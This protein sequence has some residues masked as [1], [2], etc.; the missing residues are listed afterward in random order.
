MLNVLPR[1]LAVCNWINWIAAA[2]LVVML[3][4]SVPYETVILA[5]LAE[6]SNAADAATVLSTVRL[7]IAAS[8]PVAVALHLIFTR[9]RTIVLAARD[10]DPFIADNAA[11]LR[12]IGWA[13][14]ATQ[15]LDLVFG[16]V[17]W[18]IDSRMNGGTMGWSP[19]LTAWLAVLLIFVLARVFETGAAMRDDLEGTV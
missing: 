11:R 8:I 6:H 17:S 3:I 2:L 18:Q 16:Y 19:S 7:A 5:K 10:G 1:L 13:L 9:L 4:L 14:L 12:V 15:L